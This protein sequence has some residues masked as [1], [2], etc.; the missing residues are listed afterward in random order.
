MNTDIFSEEGIPSTISDGEI[1]DRRPVE[2]KGNGLNINPKDM[3]IYAEILK[4]KFEEY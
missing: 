1:S 4:P 3:I 2:K